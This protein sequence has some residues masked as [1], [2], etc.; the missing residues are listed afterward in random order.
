MLRWLT[1]KKYKSYINYF[2][3]QR[4]KSFLTSFKRLT[5]TIFQK[6]YFSWTQTLKSLKKNRSRNRSM[7]YTSS[8]YEV[9]LKLPDWF[10][11][12]KSRSMFHQRNRIKK[13]SHTIISIN[14]KKWWVGGK[15]WQNSK[16]FHNLII[17]ISIKKGISSIWF[18]LNYKKP[19][20]NI[21]W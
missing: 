11:F 13:K 15:V 19:I 18:L 7:D 12:Q 1:L 16:P 20:A 9:I 10:H 2:W 5:T 8:S 3:I 17:K 4:E 6:P 21:L 14:T